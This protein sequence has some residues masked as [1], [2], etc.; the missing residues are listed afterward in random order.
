MWIFVEA[1]VVIG[2]MFWG[3]F[4]QLRR[5]DQLTAA[6]IEPE[7]LRYV[8]NTTVPRTW[9]VYQ[10]LQSRDD[11]LRVDRKLHFGNHPVRQRELQRKFGDVELIGLF[12]SRLEA[13]QYSILVRMYGRAGTNTISS[14]AEKKLE[15]PLFA[16]SAA[17]LPTRSLTVRRSGA[18]WKPVGCNSTPI[19][20][21]NN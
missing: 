2:L 8:G 12:G 20:P 11:G 14:Q 3:M 9:G 7:K 15:N 1:T 5:R 17:A 21:G 10:V 13:E 16:E 19:P 4:T 18:K 6:R